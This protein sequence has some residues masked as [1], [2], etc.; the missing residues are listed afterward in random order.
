[1]KT[2]YF[3]NIEEIKMKVENC[4]ILWLY[5]IILNFASLE[6]KLIFRKLE[7]NGLNTK[8]HLEFNQIC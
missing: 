3:R 5:R 6:N 2:V 1:M 7:N 4:F 8:L